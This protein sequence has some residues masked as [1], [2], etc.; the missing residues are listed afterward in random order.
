MS[1]IK[2]NPKWREK[3]DLIATQSSASTMQLVAVAALIIG[4]V[5]GTFSVL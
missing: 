1:S 4:V 3:V 2:T 5:A